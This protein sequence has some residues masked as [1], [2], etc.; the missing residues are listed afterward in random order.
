MQI[1][2]NQK[3]Q[4]HTKVDWEG[5]KMNCDVNMGAVIQLQ[6]VNGDSRADLVCGDEKTRVKEIFLN[7][8]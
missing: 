6:D 7:K 2:L 8:T 3:L 1:L 5:K 4:F